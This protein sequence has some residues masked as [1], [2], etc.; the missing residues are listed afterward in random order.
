V[1]D[2]DKARQI[3]GATHDSATITVSARWLKQAI[4]EIAAGRESQHLVLL[5][6]P[7]APSR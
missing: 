1:I 5:D 3:V 7:P 2:L 4:R 6:L